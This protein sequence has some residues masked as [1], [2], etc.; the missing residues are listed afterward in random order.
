MA[1]I[2]IRG[3]LVDFLTKIDPDFQGTFVTTAKKGKKV[4]IVK[5]INSIYETMVDILI[6]YNKFIKT[7]KGTT[8]QPNTYDP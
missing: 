1:V 6:H 5:Y 3:V 4:I 8:F 7:L 2:K